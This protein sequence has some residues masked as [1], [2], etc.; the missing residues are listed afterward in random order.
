MRIALTLLIAIVYHACVA[1]PQRGELLIY[2]GDTVEIQ[3][4]PLGPY[5]LKMVPQ[6]LADFKG[7][8]ATNL[9]RGYVGLWKLE[10]GKLVLIDVF[11]CGKIDKSIKV[12]L[13]NNDSADIIA[14]WFTGT[15][16]IEKGRILPDKN[17][18]DVGYSLCYE[19]EI[20]IR[21]E[22]GI[23]ISDEEFVNG[24]KLGDLRFSRNL[25]DINREVYSKI[26][27]DSLP[28]ISTGKKLLLIIKVNDL[29]KIEYTVH[30]QIGAA[31]TQQIV[32]IMENFPDVQ[33]VHCRGKPIVES[34]EVPIAF[35]SESRRK[36]AR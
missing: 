26:D 9:W 20:V 30:G 6:V 28:E 34:W 1:T 12:L 29:G 32:R 33:V 13:F 7:G 14:D 31:Y 22:K 17:Y 11:L 5:I 8:C 4:E 36:Y 19:H 16:F 27:W 24:I 3:G 23:V 35:S 2:R 25:D 18:K 21:I 15:L 10:E